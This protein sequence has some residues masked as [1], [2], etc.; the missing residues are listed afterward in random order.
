MA[1][2][3]RRLWQP[4]PGNFWFWPSTSSYPDI[5]SSIKPGDILLFASGNKFIEQAQKA[6]HD[7]F[8][9]L[10]KRLPGIVEYD[11]T[12][13]RWTHAA[14]FVD[15]DHLVC[16]AMPKGGVQ[17]ASFEQRA[18]HSEPIK[19][20]RHRDSNEANG[21]DVAK[22]AVSYRRRKYNLKD[23]LNYVFK[24]Q[25]PDDAIESLI[26]STLCA[27]ALIDAGM[28][29]NKTKDMPVTP[30][31]LSQAKCLVAVSFVYLPVATPSG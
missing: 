10:E 26:C 6:R 29:M 11:E 14:I 16:E 23:C 31:F 22:K 21:R 3:N 9:S 1:E 19:V 13:W 30:A 15:A 18:A 17:V 4:S 27:R 25:I 28:V 5:R 2:T 7:Y 20:L 24:G 12:A 8:K